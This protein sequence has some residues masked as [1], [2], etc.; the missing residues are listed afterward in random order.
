MKGGLGDGDEES[1]K[2][3]AR[4]CLFSHAIRHLSIVTG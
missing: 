2:Y 1:M 4:V 3:G